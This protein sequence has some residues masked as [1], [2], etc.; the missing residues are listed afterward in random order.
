MREIL[1]ELV[2]SHLQLCYT[3]NTNDI[4][5]FNYLGGSTECKTGPGVELHSRFCGHRFAG[6]RGATR[7][8]NYVCGKIEKKQKS[9][10]IT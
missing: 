2:A 10:L 1:L 8:D 5:L 6:V 9:P 7:V 3:G 4:L